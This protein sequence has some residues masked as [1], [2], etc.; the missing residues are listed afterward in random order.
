MGVGFTIAGLF[1][2]KEYVDDPT[3]GNMKNALIRLAVGAMLILL[4]FVISTSATTM[5]AGETT[6]FTRSGINTW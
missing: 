1:K 2:L 6:T 3:S 4:P 5:D